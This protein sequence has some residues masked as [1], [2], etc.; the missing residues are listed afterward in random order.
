MLPYSKLLIFKNCESKFDESFDIGCFDIGL[1]LSLMFE[2]DVVK[3]EK[4]DN[5]A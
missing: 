4:C 5:C 3:L 2:L 1:V